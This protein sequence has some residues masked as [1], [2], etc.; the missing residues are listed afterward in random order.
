MAAQHTGEWRCDEA[1]A[2]G[3]W[4]LHFDQGWK[5]PPLLVEGSRHEAAMTDQ[6]RSHAGE[7]S[8][9][10]GSCSR[11]TCLGEDRCPETLQRREKEQEE[12]EMKVEEKK[13]VLNAGIGQKTESVLS[14]GWTADK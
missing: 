13:L 1:G 8:R 2:A 14:L 10:V 5:S 3:K 6:T 9:D 12:E 7:S 11:S 4:R